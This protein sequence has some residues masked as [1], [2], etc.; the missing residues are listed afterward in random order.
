MQLNFLLLCFTLWLH[1]GTNAESRPKG[2]SEDFELLVE[3]LVESR[4]VDM[5]RRLEEMEVRNEK[6]EAINKRMELRLEGT[7]TR[8][9]QVEAKITLLQTRIQELED[10]ENKVEEGK[11]PKTGTGRENEMSPRDLPITLISAWRFSSVTSP[12]TV[13]FDSFLVNF[14]NGDTPGG[15]DGLFDLG[16]GI[17]TC[18]TPGYY[19]VSFSAL[20][21]AGPTFGD[22]L[23][24]SH[25]YLYKN[26]LK[27]DESHWVLGDDNHHDNES[28]GVTSSRIV[29][30]FIVTLRRF[31]V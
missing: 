12:Q 22:K 10:K 5:K 14:N 6:L 4:M 8:N 17:F 24:H 18:L 19:S 15:G 9:E 3:K 29:V 2:N 30:S 27:L 11:K 7:A 26:G 21:V 1:T 25:L 28:I 13:T 23:N 20:G 16:T 31:K